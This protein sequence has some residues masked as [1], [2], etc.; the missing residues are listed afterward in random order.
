MQMSE[1]T[2]DQTP[3]VKKPRRKRLYQQPAEIPVPKDAAHEPVM[4]EV[5]SMRFPVPVASSVHPEFDPNAEREKRAMEI[6]RRCAGYGS[7]VSLFP[8][9][10]LDNIVVG[11]MHLKMVRELSEFYGIEYPRRRAVL[12]I[13][14]L[15]WGIGL[16]EITEWAGKKLLGGIPVIGGV[17]SWAGSAAMVGAVTYALGKV[18]VYHFAVGGTLFDFDP[19]ATRDFFKSAFREAQAQPAR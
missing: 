17:A 19:K 8:V 15:M 7:V 13:S 6:V 16:P 11:A 3:V 10:L 2:S 1:G 14:T 5:V 4:P 12:V 9:P 18:L